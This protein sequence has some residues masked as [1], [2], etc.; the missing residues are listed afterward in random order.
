MLSILANAR[1]LPLPAAAARRTSLVSEES[2]GFRHFEA[3]WPVGSSVNRLRLLARGRGPMRL[4]SFESRSQSEP[5]LT[6]TRAWFCRVRIQSSW[7][8]RSEGR[9][10]NRLSGRIARRRYGLQSKIITSEFRDAEFTES[11]SIQNRL[12]IV[13]LT[14]VVNTHT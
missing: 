5:R 4:G 10:L 8:G 11:S 14:V 12:R 7:F 1:M 3:K 13:P 6:D 2:L 9:A